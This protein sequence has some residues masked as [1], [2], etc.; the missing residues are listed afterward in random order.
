MAFGGSFLGRLRLRAVA[1]LSLLGRI[2]ER[3]VV[4]AILAGIYAAVVG[5]L[6]AALYDPI[7][8]SAA[9]T[10]VDAGIA[11]IALVLLQRFKTPPIVIAAFCVCSSLAISMANFARPGLFG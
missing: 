3:K 2:A 10:V 5:L 8:V 1:G 4:N 9:H 6:A 11:L 7:W